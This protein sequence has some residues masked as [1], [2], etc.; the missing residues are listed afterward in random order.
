MNITTG[1]TTPLADAATA[2]DITAA[3]ERDRQAAAA[4]AG[5]GDL[6]RSEAEALMARARE[7]AARIIAEAEAAARP[8][9]KAADAADNEAAALAG[10]AHRLDRA[11]GFAAQAGA[12]AAR[13][14][15]LEAERDDLAAKH[16]DLG[17]RLAE[18][19]AERRGKEAALATARDDADLD[20]ITALRTRLDAIADLEGTLRARQAQ[21][22]ARLD[23]I[24]DGEMSPIWP[25]RELAEAR[26]VAGM[27]RRQ[28]RAMLNDAW[29]ERPEAVADAARQ[30][31]QLLEYAASEQRAA[32]RA[33]QAP[34]R[35]QTFLG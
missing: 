4:A 30:H 27:D 26:R 20:L 1:M 33:R 6:A 5:R 15:T 18:L 17:G 19:A 35:R 25:Q 24:G 31:E 11:A 12:S 8:L 16:A 23:A 9:T 13:V 34:R 29:P 28:V 3:A 22:T 2:A 21:L 7:D 32:E 10:R 14:K